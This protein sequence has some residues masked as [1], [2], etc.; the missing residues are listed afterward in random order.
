MSFSMWLQ[1]RV[2]EMQKTEGRMNH[3]LLC[4][5]MPPSIVA[6]SLQIITTYGIHYKVDLEEGMPYHAIYDS[7]I[8]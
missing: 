5:S 2:M 8:T 7:G 1:T 3:V 4:L 6:I